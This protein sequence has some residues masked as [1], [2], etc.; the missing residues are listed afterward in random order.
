MSNGSMRGDRRRLTGLCG[1]AA[2]L[3]IASMLVGCEGSTS[4]SAV[5]GEW[6]GAVRSPLGRYHEARLDLRKDGRF[7]MLFD[8]AVQNTSG[9]WSFSDGEMI[10]EYTGEAALVFGTQICTVSLEKAKTVKVMHWSG[11][12]PSVRNN[13]WQRS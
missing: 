7:R 11:C 4:K 3:F 5:I 1:C 2:L 10:L 6:T 13:R 8:N 12:Q 9:R